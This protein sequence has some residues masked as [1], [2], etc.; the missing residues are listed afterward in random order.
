MKRARV[1]LIFHIRFDGRRTSYTTVGGGPSKF[2]MCAQKMRIFVYAIYMVRICARIRPQFRQGFNVFG[3]DCRC[4]LV[5]VKLLLLSVSISRCFGMAEVGTTFV[6]S[7]QKLSD[8]KLSSA[9]YVY[10]ATIPFFIYMR[11]SLNDW[12]KHADSGTTLQT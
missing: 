7:D 2:E 1:H 12:H 11:F 5:W 10:G 9:R 4:W 6:L 8:Q 3:D